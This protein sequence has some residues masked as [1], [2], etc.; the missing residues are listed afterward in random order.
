M[1][2][3]IKIITLIL[4]LIPNAYAENIFDCVIKTNDIAGNQISAKLVITVDAEPSATLKTGDSETGVFGEKDFILSYGSHRGKLI[5]TS[6]SYFLNKGSYDLF[7]TY[8]A[9]KNSNMY[10]R[11]VFSESGFNGLVHSLSI[12]TWEKNMPIYFY[13]S[14]RPRS[15]IQGSCK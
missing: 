5:I 13:L 9:E 1:K 11:G 7:V 2:K 15:V 3:F 14:D 8:N 10:F 12:N 6:E 4:L